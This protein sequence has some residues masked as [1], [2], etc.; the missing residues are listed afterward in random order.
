MVG[1]LLGCV[2]EKDRMKQKSEKSSGRKIKTP[3]S[4]FPGHIKFH[5]E[6]M[7]AYRVFSE[8]TLNDLTKIDAWKYF[9]KNIDAVKMAWA[10]FSN[11]IDKLE[12]DGI[13][14]K[15]KYN[16]YSPVNPPPLADKYAPGFYIKN[17]NFHTFMPI[18]LDANR[19]IHFYEMDT[20]EDGQPEG[21][22]KKF[23]PELNKLAK[24][25]KDSV[26]KFQN[27]TG[28]KSRMVIFTQR[29]NDERE[30]VSY[31]FDKLSER[32]YDIIYNE[33]QISM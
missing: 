33:P 19:C 6:Y 8:N 7:G 20:N 11:T 28:M 2:M 12:Q 22:S 24:E 29:R 26:E 3:Y 16:K 27:K 18:V 15:N 32:L 1:H 17:D 31:V 21:I 10:T 23:L 9:K 30:V 4:Y 25:L 13:I 5:K 14:K